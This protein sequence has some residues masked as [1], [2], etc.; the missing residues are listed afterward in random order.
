[1]ELVVL[2]LGLWRNFALPDFDGAAAVKAL[3]AASSQTPRKWVVKPADARFSEEALYFEDLKAGKNLLTTIEITLRDP[4][5]TS[6]S[7]LTAT[8]G[9][10]FQWLPRPD[11]G[12]PRVLQFQPGTSPLNSVLMLTVSAEQGQQLTVSQISLRRFYPSPK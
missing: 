3:G 6:L 10:Q 4:W 2:L 9:S 7:A 5:H 12:R 11:Q 1:M 8:F